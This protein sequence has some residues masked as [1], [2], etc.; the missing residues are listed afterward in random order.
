MEIIVAVPGR[1]ATDGTGLDRTEGCVSAVRLGPSEISY[2]NVARRDAVG[3]VRDIATITTSGFRAFTSAY[4]KSA[5]QQTLRSQGLSLAP[6]F[7][8]PSP[9]FEEAG[10]LLPFAS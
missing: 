3:G 4:S 8:H 7:W 10:A 9:G 2:G 1:P 6:S 5:T